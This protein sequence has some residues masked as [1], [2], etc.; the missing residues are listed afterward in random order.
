[1]YKRSCITRASMWMIDWHRIHVVTVIGY[2]YLF[3]RAL[4]HSNVC[5][6]VIIQ[7]TCMNT[8]HS[9]VPCDPGDPG[10]PGEPVSPFWP[11]FPLVPSVPGSPGVPGAPGLPFSPS[12]PSCPVKDLC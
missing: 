10:E 6:F 4:L 5:M 3:P 1:M 9:H 8:S 7:C 11:G 12:L 2:L